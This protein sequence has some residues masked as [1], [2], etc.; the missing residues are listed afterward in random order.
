MKEKK[1]N[2]RKWREAEN[3]R[4]RGPVLRDTQ[5]PARYIEPRFSYRYLST[6]KRG[7][8]G[9]PNLPLIHQIW[10]TS[11][12][13]QPAIYY[14]RKLGNGPGF[15]QCRNFSRIRSILHRWCA[16][17]KSEFSKCVPFSYS[18]PYR[19][20][21][22]ERTFGHLELLLLTQGPIHY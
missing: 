21:G 10:P 8:K 16:R 1:V 18:G 14:I 22:L 4:V 20:P 19:S 15:I 13:P 3:I 11:F 5:P 9:H 7:D 2:E 12:L 6:V 17:R